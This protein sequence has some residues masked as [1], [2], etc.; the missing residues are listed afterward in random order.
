MPLDP[1]MACRAALGYAV[2][3]ELEQLERED[4]L[5]VCRPYPA[6]ISISDRLAQAVLLELERWPYETKASRHG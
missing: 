3:R 2:R 5:M 4:V 1:A 6:W